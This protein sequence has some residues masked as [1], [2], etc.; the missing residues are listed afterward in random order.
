MS[1]DKRTSLDR[2][3]TDAGLTT[4]T[5]NSG[6]GKARPRIVKPSLNDITSPTDQQPDASSGG[7]KPVRG[8]RKSLTGRLPSNSP[9]LAPKP[10]TV[11]SPVTSL[12]TPPST[13][14]KN[15][16]QGPRKSV[17]GSVA[18]PVG[19]RKSTTPPEKSAVNSSLST[20]S[21]GTRRSVPAS[22][23]TLRGTLQGNKSPRASPRSTRTPQMTPKSSS[24]QPASPRPLGVSR[25]SSSPST[26]ANEQN[27]E[28]PKLLKEGTFTK[29]PSPA[30]QTV[31][32]DQPVTEL[33]SVHEG[34]SNLKGKDVP[35]EL[36][37]VLNITTEQ[38]SVGSVE[39][40]S[41]NK[42]N[43]FNDSSNTSVPSPDYIASLL[44]DVRALGKTSGA[45][46]SVGNLMTVN[47]PTRAALPRSGPTTP[48]IGRKSIDSQLTEIAA[49]SK[50]STRNKISSLWHRDKP[51]KSDTDK[52]STAVHS[53][54]NST[55]SD[56]QEKT[57]DGLGKSPKSFQKS[58]PLRKSR[59]STEKSEPQVAETK[60][61]RSGTYDVIDSD[62]KT[63]Q[64]SPSSDVVQNCT[65]DIHPDIV[66]PA[67]DNI[68]STVTHNLRDDANES[69]MHPGASKGFK[70]LSFFKKFTKD[71]KDK[72]KDDKSVELSKSEVATGPLKKKGFS[73]WRRDHSSS[74]KKTK[75]KSCDREWKGH[76]DGVVK[77]ATL[78]SDALVKASQS[79][80]SLSQLRVSLSV[81]TEAL[82]SSASSRRASDVSTTSPH[83]TELSSFEFGGSAD[84]STKQPDQQDA[85]SSVLS[86][87]CH[88]GN[89]LSSEI[90]S[91]TEAESPHRRRTTCTSIVTTV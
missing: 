19:R 46:R 69:L 44:L 5:P 10:Q 34:N 49:A 7:P 41:L 38:P 25:K 89:L 88:G 12:R 32:V 56:T 83:S 35:A 70:G 50:K 67:S 84:P 24:C 36:P 71:S 43:A 1:E 75:K 76:S 4:S 86:G 59:K 8:K 85:T 26:T 87:S 3:G 28:R 74:G 23:V 52:S 31:N 40:E 14:T 57:R 2:L 16:P 20:K 79:S 55:V 15:S 17:T 90:I 77:S 30:V 60:L 18:S 61:M 58:F 65:A 64:Q 63:I 82:V 51:A 68:I 78:P 62:G 66:C 80:D 42:S 9:K 39:V 29:E 33:S 81:T 13:F 37:A 22:P 48:T 91:D 73:L 11:G 72:L 27:A 53:Q 6:S 54:Q 47:S 45:S 21:E